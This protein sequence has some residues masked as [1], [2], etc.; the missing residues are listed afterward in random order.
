MR[1]RDAWKRRPLRAGS[2]KIKKLMHSSQNTDT[3]ESGST[4]IKHIKDTESH[5]ACVHPARCFGRTSALPLLFPNRVSG[6][7]SVA[8]G[9]VDSGRRG[10]NGPRGSRRGGKVQAK[11]LDGSPRNRTMLQTGVRE[12]LKWKCFLPVYDGMTSETDKVW[13]YG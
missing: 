8:D 3:F 7:I 2:P 5:S 1:V 13:G 12:G 10:Q 6:C 4:Q 11:G 9:E